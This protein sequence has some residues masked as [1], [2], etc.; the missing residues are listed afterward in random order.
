MGVLA[1]L[2]P[3]KRFVFHWLFLFML[4]MLSFH[5]HAKLAGPRVLGAG[6]VLLGAGAWLTLGP[7]QASVG[8]A[9]ALAIALVR[10]KA[11]PLVFLGMISYSLYLIHYPIGTRLVNLGGR[12][13]TGPGTSLAL[14]AA[15]LG[16]MVL[17][18]WALY[19]CV[20]RP[21]QRWATACFARPTTAG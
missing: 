2:L 11:R 7:L 10:F 18:A 9:T 13:V 3:E 8:V 1:V 6:L 14:V 12:Y 17:C 19:F 4:G 21:A 15:V 16:I 20:E 5:W